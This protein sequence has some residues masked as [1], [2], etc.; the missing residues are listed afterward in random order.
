[1]QSIWPLLPALAVLVIVAVPELGSDP[2][3]FVPG[4]LETRAAGMA[5]PTRRLRWDVA[6]L[7]ASA[8]AGGVLV[9]AGAALVAMGLAGPRGGFRPRSRRCGASRVPGSSCRSRFGT[10]PSRG[11]SPTILRT[12]SSWPATSLLDGEN[13][14]GHD[15]GSL[16]LENFYS[17][18]GT[19]GA[20]PKSRSRSAISPTSREPRTQPRSGA[21]SPSRSTT[22]GCSS[23]SRPSASSAPRFSFRPAPWRL[24]AGTVLA[25]NSFAV[26]AAWFGIAVGRAS[27]SSSSRSPSAP[28]PGSPPPPPAW[29]GRSSWSESRSSPCRSSA[30]SCG[31]RGS[32]RELWKPAAAFGE[33]LWS[34]PTVRR[35]RRTRR[36][37]D[38]TIAY[39][40]DAYG[41]SGTESRKSS[42]N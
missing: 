3:L 10:H 38:D 30:R 18:D 20:Q 12:R 27:S 28:D 8:L 19:V 40:A 36:S 9:A 22:T 41:S 1:M 29:R 17:L 13:P 39:G 31:P 32:Q 14:Y 24:A 21:S 15:Y 37:I 7:R 5:R 4:P 16:G 34:V 11:S 42:S 26:R 6:L 35:R 25:A 23:F 33:V 2:W